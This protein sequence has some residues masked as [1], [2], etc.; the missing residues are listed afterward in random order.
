L[1]LTRTGKCRRE[2]ARAFQQ[3][4]PESLFTGA[5]HP[6]A[7]LAGIMLLIGCWEESHDLAQDIA[8][9]EGSYW[10]AIVHR[11]EPDASNSAYW[12]RRV[13]RH[14]IFSALHIEA[15]KITDRMAATG[16]N[17]KTTWDPF[18][19][20]DWCEEARL[21]SGSTKEQLARQIQQAEWRLL[22]EWCASGVN[23]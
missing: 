2:H 8:T 15:S 11:M 3:V 1:P 20:I 9:V 18:L 12:F 4:A 17:L 22:F 5:R 19:F 23:L 14:P 16:W 6:E 21:Q 13:G 7:A 10:H